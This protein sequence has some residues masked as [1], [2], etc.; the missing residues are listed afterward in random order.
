MKKLIIMS[1]LTALIMAG[2][3]AKST[4]QETNNTSADVEPAY[5]LA[6]KVQGDSSAEISATFS[7]RIEDLPVNVGDVVKKGESLVV[8]ETSDLSAQSKVAEAAYEAAQA[9]YARAV[10]GARPEQIQQAEAS[11]SAA[12]LTWENA[13]KNLKRNTEL[14]KINAISE[15]QYET[16]K[17]QTEASKASYKA[18]EEQLT[19]LKN[20]ETEEYMTILEKQVKQAKASWEALKTTENNRTLKAPFDGVVVSCPVKVGESYS[21]MTNLM[22]LENRTVL[23]I[24]AYGPMTAVQHFEVGQDVAVRVA[25]I[26]QETFEGKVTW[27]GDSID[28][29]RR[30]VLV[31]VEL[32]SNEKLAAGMYAE[33]GIGQ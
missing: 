11:Y 8:F 20:G 15:A 5:Y 6:G 33:I 22:T 9:Q 2:C 21:S 18:A 29:D 12:K 19:M 13:D 4:L 3:G 14:Y 26:S 16:V 23:T 28:S 27:V 17:S 1:L 24:D 31:K 32:G 25:E 30:A 10:K 7:G